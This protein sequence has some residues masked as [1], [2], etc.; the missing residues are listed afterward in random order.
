MQVDDRRNDRQPQPEPRMAVAFLTA[1]EALQHR[2]TL[3]FRNTRPAVLDGQVHALLVLRRANPHLPT[4]GGELDTVAHQV[5]QCL[6][7]QFAVTVQCR[8]FSG[9]LQFQANA[10][11]LGQRQV[12]I[13][14]LHQQFVRVELDETG[15]SLAVFQ[16]ADAQ[17]TAK[18]RHQGVGFAD[19]LVQ[20]LGLGGVD[21]TLLANAV[22]LGAQA[23]ER[24][25]QVV[26][27]VV[28]HALDLVHQPLDA[29]EHGIDDGRQHVQLVT[30]GRQR[31]AVGKVAGDDQ[32]GLGLDRANALERATPQQ[33]PAGKARDQG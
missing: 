8:Q 10:T 23:R 30:P 21:V 19:G 16:L 6:E 32:F 1:I 22:Q 25:A 26:G 12:E 18:T 3:F 5:G 9:L 24:G 27:D 2:S 20:C 11:I 4:L 29:V 13:M 28:A 17:Q 14:Q 15:P 7:Q 31:Q 33:V